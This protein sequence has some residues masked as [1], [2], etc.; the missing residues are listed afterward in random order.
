MSQYRV[1]H[2][3]VK[4]IRDNRLFILSYRYKM[5]IFGEYGIGFKC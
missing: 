1:R 2:H 4:N 3:Y 5:Y